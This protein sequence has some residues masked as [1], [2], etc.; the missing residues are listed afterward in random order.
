[1]WTTLMYILVAC[2]CFACYRFFTTEPYFTWKNA[3]KTLGTIERVITDEKGFHF[4]IAFQDQNDDF[5]HAVSPRYVY[6][7]RPGI[8]DP[9]K[10]ELSIQL[11][12]G[13]TVPISYYTIWIFHFSIDAIRIEDESLQK[14]EP[15]KAFLFLAYFLVVMVVLRVLLPGALNVMISR[16]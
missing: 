5:H 13:E 1:M 15:Y 12:I 11:A 3:G 6:R 2:F 14:K 8:Q 9:N 16:I 4:Q 10:Q 7:S